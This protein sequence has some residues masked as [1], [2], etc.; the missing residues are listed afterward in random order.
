[1]TRSGDLQV[2]KECSAFTGLAGDYCTITSSNLDEIEIGARVI[3]AEAAGPDVLDTDIVLDAGGG[4]TV[5][6]HVVLDLATARGEVIF[7][8]GTGRFTGFGARADVW[9]D[10]EG[11][12]HW[13][14]TYSFSPTD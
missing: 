6:G 7:T 9:D 13:D 4:N 5:N 12:S 2:I 11:L 3:Y 10:A 8:G 14:G 1:M